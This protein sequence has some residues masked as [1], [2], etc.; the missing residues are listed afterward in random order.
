MNGQNS[1][2]RAA[3]AAAAKTTKTRTKGADRE[4]L[5]QPGTLKVVTAHG[6]LI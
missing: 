5:L 4:V 2:R 3:A 6:R 1:C